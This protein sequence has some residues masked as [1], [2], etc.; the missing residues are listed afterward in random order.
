MQELGEVKVQ[1]IQ[2]YQTK[3]CWRVRES[4]S[5]VDV[6]MKQQKIDGT[7]TASKD[8]LNEDDDTQYFTDIT[9]NE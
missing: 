2:T 9:K 4:W 3:D 8:S 6:H 7:G 5:R 1:C